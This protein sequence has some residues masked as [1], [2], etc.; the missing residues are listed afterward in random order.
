MEK[1]YKR[2]WLASVAGIAVCML[3]IATIVI[4]IDPFYSYHLPLFG[5]KAENWDE[6]YCNPGLIRHSDYDSALVG[7]SMTAQ[8]RA[9]E[10]GKLLG[11]NYIK[12]KRSSGTSKDIEKMVEL[13]QDKNPNLKNVIFGI[14]IKMLKKTSTEYRSELPEYLYDTNYFNDVGYWFNEEV[15]FKF[16]YELY[17]CNKNGTIV[18]LDDAFIRDATEYGRDITLQRYTRPRIQ[19]GS[20]VEERLLAS[21]RANINNII[22]T[23]SQNMNTHYDV[24]IPPY[25]ILYWDQRIRENTLEAEYK[26]QK[27]AFEALFE[28]PN[29]TVHYFM[30]C[31][32][33]VTDLDNYRDAGHYSPEICSKLLHYIKSGEKQIT[34]Q[35]YVQILDAWFEYVK[36]HD[37]EQYFSEG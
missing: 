31:E 34:S 10:T 5:W 4:I 8:F 26:L 11:G 12:V 17:L 20:E 28:C 29:V 14:D 15:L 21:G 33:I 35:N 37:Y 36:N 3:I 13:L 7:T 18:N 1:T 9:S 6:T 2:L 19:D 27:E 32:E 24:F 25:S 22:S 23:I 16:A 30:D